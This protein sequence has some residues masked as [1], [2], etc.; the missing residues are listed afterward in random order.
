M[1]SLWPIYIMAA[2]I[3]ITMITA[4]AADQPE[5][6]N[7]YHKGYRFDRN[8][9][10]Y[11]HI[12]GEPYDR[13]FQYGYL[14]APEL[15]EIM[16]TIRYMTIWD[17]GKDWD[18]FINA[19]E[20]LFIPRMD[21]E[22]LLEIKGI[23][24]GANA[25]KINLTWQDIL[26]WNGY[27][28]LTDYWWP[29][30]LKG[31]QSMGNKAVK[32]RCSA[33]MAT[34]NATSDGKIVIAHNTWDVFAKGQFYNLILDIKPAEGHRIFMQSILG[35]IDGDTDFFVTN[36]GLVGTETTIGGFESYQPYAAP[37]FLRSRKAMQYS[38]TMDQFVKI[39]SENRSGGEADSWLLGDTN[40]GEIMRFELG[41]NYSNTTRTKDGYFIGFNAPIDPSIRNLECSNTGYADIR[42]PNGAR[43]VRLTQLM[44]E[45]YGKIDVN[46]AKAILADHFDVY[47]KT[48]NPSSRTIDGHYELDAE[49]YPGGE[50][51]PFYPEGTLDGKVANA[52]MVK[53]MS[54]W[55]RWGSSSGMPFDAA[56]FL[57]EH[58]QY[59][60]LKGY[61]KDRPARPWTI[62]AA[63]A[64][65]AS[66]EGI[67]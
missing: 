42:H 2:L 31:M 33:F 46:V 1:R 29:Y 34:G 66:G 63:D 60:D 58:I 54:F 67:I 35:C 52:T 20:D 27:S 22:Y 6:F 14:A 48:I 57:K 65:N 7:S 3:A 59:G 32:G 36:A 61:L 28:E 18:F 21:P 64:G 15:G 50:D 37:S 16:N 53:D 19:S 62:F 4:V 23:A 44:E 39:I 8:G 12:E 38:G 26:A 9:W 49:E 17:T 30:E 55:A 41:L 47:L 56:E 40:T 10:I 51:L 5:N 45:N 13:G 25:R 24:A 11:I 43:Q